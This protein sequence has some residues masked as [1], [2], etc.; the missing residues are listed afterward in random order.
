MDYHRPVLLKESVDG[1][2]IKP[3][4]VYVDATFG[5]GGHSREILSRLG[6]KGTLLGF[7]QD[8]DAKKNIPDDKRF[9]FA[10]NNFRFIRN[11]LKYYDIDQVDGILADLGVSSH[12]FD[13]AERGF[14]FRFDE[15]LDMRMN[16]SQ[17]LTAEQVVNTYDEQT[18]TKIFTSYG[19]IVNGRRLAM[20]IIKDRQA[21]PI[22]LTGQLKE[23]VLKCYG[24]QNEAKLMPPV[25][26][27]LRI[28]VNK[29]LKVLEELLEASI[30][31]LKPGG[32]LVVITYHSLED[33]IVKHFMKA[34]RLDGVVEKD[35]Y[36]NTSCCFEQVTRKAIVPGEEELKENPRSRSAKLRIVELK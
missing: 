9:L 26:Q 23:I 21:N 25:F 34:G 8:D 32:R 35:F 17:K 15:R 5:G 31:V 30:D 13:A 18:L 24:K 6:K 3:A 27:A 19:E 36:G 16:Q 29:E 20:E 1:L 11:F 33:R 7:D 28:E 14:S 4:G 22:T 12:H 10:D 2:N